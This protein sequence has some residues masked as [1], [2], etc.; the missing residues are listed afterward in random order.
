MVERDTWGVWRQDSPGHGTALRGLEYCGDGGQCG[1]LGALSDA[2]WP[3][4]G[5]ERRSNS[6]RGSKGSPS[7]SLERATPRDSLRTPRNT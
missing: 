3:C 6:G 4:R 2:V 1:N 7:G 5:K